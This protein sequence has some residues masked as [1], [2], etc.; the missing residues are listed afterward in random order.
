MHISIITAISMC[1]SVLHAEEWSAGS[2]SS[3][4]N[5]ISRISQ[6]LFESKIDELTP[7]SYAHNER[8]YSYHLSSVRYLGGVSRGDQHFTVASVLFIRSSPKGSET[9]P[10]RGHGLSWT[11][12]SGH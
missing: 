7:K 12:N 11:P 6:A 2:F 9:P 1:A 3:E 4:A 5:P 8:S 10:A